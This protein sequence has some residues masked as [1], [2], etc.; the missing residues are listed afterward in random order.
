[1]AASSGHV[2]LTE[3]RVHYSR[4]RRS[5]LIGPGA[6]SAAAAARSILGAQAQQEGPALFALSRRTRGRPPASELR[7]QLLDARSRRLIRTWG[8]RDTLH[9]FDPP[10]WPV[11]VAA[12]REWPQSGRRGALPSE[13]DLDAIRS[14]FERASGP[15]FRSELF[16][17]IPKRFVD[18]VARHPGV[19]ASG[20]S[21]VRFAAARLVWRLALA[22]DIC[23]AEK[24]GAEQS[25]VHRRLWF[26]DLAWHEDDPTVA[27][28]GLARRY[29]GVHGPASAADLAHFF[30]SGVNAA[31]S[32]LDRLSPELVEVECGE[33]RGLFALRDDLKALT[34]R[35]PKGLTGWPVTLLP[36]W[37]THLMRH[38]DK[39]WLMPD[40]SERKLVWRKAGDISATA[41]ARGRIVATW[42]HR[43][44]KRRVKVTV[45][46]LSAWRK[47]HL[48]G[49][50]REAAAF[51]A[52]LEVPELEL[53]I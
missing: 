3:E 15:L 30:G 7:E 20:G 18:E 12:R 34:E 9:V 44:T 53:S 25:Y 19:A 1:M 49:I 37:D 40:E 39:S 48:G 33:R 24:R 42:T 36:K 13:P 23:F 2:A 38:R 22:G 50:K 52:F 26:P 28:T 45:T 6:S 16:E 4:D 43:V 29:L 17:A 32:W 31:R 11:V 14:L 47:Q 21:A 5:H 10:D 27:A 35:P 8:Q 51:A 46:P 41:V